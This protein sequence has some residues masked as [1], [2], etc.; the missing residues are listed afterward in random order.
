[1]RGALH[2]D[3]GLVLHTI[4]QSCMAAC[5]GEGVFDWLL[6]GSF[7]FFTK[8]IL[9]LFQENLVIRY[10][11]KQDYELMRLFCSDNWMG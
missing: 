3:A 6:N 5:S 9:N 8:K 4:D 7:P 1:M 11:C 2:N 10:C